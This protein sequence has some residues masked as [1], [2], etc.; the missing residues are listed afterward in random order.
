MIRPKLQFSNIFKKYPLG[1]R[2]RVP[3]IKTQHH[4]EKK[5]WPAGRGQKIAKIE[6]LA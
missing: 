3:H 1:N 2:P 4:R 6:I 5:L